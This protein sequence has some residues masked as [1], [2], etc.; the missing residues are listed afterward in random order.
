MAYCPLAEPRGKDPV[1]LLPIDHGF[2][3]GTELKPYFTYYLYLGMRQELF[4]KKLSVILTASDLFST[5][6]Q[7]TFL[8]TTFL[9][10]TS[11]GRRDGLAVYLG[12][13]YRFRKTIKKANEENLQFHNNMQ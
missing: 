8:N 12:V 6:R 4:N 3:I 5:H 10:Q 1:G 13:S 7:K 11:I 2:N 9:E